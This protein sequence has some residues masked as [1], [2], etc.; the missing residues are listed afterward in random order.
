M[1]IHKKDKNPCANFTLSKKLT[2]GVLFTQII[3]ISLLYIFVI[4]NT[5][6][7][8][9]DY[10]INS[11]ETI[12]QE[13]AQIVRN[14]VKETENILTAYSRAG[15]ITALLQNPTDEK[16]FAAAQKYTET[17]SGDVANLEGLYASEWNTHV[18]THTNAGVVGITTREGDPLKAL[19]DSMLKAKGVYNTGIIISP[20]S[21]QQ[22]VSLYRAVLN[23]AGEPIGLVGGGVFTTGLIEM[24]NELDDSEYYMINTKNNQY[25]FHADAKK[26]ATDVKEKYLKDLSSSLSNKVNNENGYIE[27]TRDGRNYISTY[28]YM[29]DYGWIFLVENPEDTIF[30]SVYR[31]KTIV[32]AISMIAIMILLF[33]TI[34]FIRKLTKPLKDI[35]NSILELKDLNI[36]E[37]EAIKKFD[38]RK[39]EIGNITKA[40]QSLVISL[41]DII[42]TLKNCCS[43]LD[44]KSNELHTSST[45]LIEYTTDNMATTEEFSASIEDTNT[46]VS[47]IGQEIS[48]INDIVEN[49]LNNI[50][51]S[52]DSSNETIKNAQ[53]MKNQADVAYNNGQETLIKTKSSV[54]E[55][56]E[57]LKELEKI[58]DLAAEILKIAGQTNL[59]SLNASIEAARAG[60]AGRGFAVVAGEIGTLADTSKN[61]A[62]A[63]QTLCNE[64]NESIKTV[65]SCF[66][67]I[68]NFIEEDVV[69]EF[70]DF[71]E[72][73]ATCTQ[74]VNDIK[75]QLD[76][77]EKAVR[78]LYEYVMQI[79]ENMD[80]VQQITNENRN[81]ISAIVDK[82]EQTSLVSEEIQKQSEENKDLANQLDDIIAQFKQ[83]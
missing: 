2:I 7:S 34:T 41:G 33:V 8:T 46:I 83:K 64:A 42:Y 20:A 32:I 71:V 68:V 80:N 43:T 10:A 5:S 14:Y 60:E 82:N 6:K 15:E 55:A 62:S 81:A 3:V 54:Q 47:N 67:T 22:I 59:L 69:E 36:S 27:Y 39:D 31:L 18:L 9:K 24:L 26:T 76:A 78:Q 73:S 72:K 17:F 48:D 28:T 52:V 66:D 58:N 63:I 16:A 77:T 57:S 61:T 11:M 21:G 30:A 65:S 44:I 51:T 23:D 35:E 4:N 37:K 45:S 13:R 40:I 12:T 49:V 75:N 50:T 70:K 53:L 29:A 19:Q 79:A 56:L 1:N 74:E 38:S 25:I